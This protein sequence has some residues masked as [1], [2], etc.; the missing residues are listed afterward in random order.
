MAARILDGSAIAIALTNTLCE[1]QSERVVLISLDA[2][3]ARKEFRS[4][5][6]AARGDVEAM[7]LELAAY[8][9]HGA[10]CA[11]VSR[12]SARCLGNRFSRP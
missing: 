8:T 6:H 2:D 5:S 4:N 12:L 10:M 7:A 1:E 9:L 11:P 3:A